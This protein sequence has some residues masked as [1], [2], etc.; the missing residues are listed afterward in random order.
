MYE[1]II[2]E[3][4]AGSGNFNGSLVVSISKA[5][6]TGSC[7]WE[8]GNGITGTWS[9]WC[10]TYRTIGFIFDSSYL[11]GFGATPLHMVPMS[12]IDF[13]VNGNP[14]VIWNIM[15]PDVKDVL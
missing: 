12:H 14:H 1:I 2:M 7:V 15:F 6:T 5:R 3:S 9:G 10:T 11:R 8:W 13:A 4:V